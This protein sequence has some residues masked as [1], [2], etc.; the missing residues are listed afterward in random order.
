LVVFGQIDHFTSA[1]LLYAVQDYRFTVVICALIMSFKAY[2][3]Q[4]FA[5]FCGVGGWDFIFWEDGLKWALRNTGTTVYAGVRIDVK[6]RP[7]GNWE[8]RNDT[9]NRADFN[10]PGVSKT[11]AGNYVRHVTTSSMMFDVLVKIFSLWG[12]V[13]QFILPE[14]LSLRF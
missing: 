14:N 1:Q 7:L 6:P 4:V 12:F 13:R 8:T 9:F 11:K 2:P 5:T 10:A 3:V